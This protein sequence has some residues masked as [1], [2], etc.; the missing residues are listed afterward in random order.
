MVSVGAI[1][2]HLLD[3][4]FPLSAALREAYALARAM[5][6]PA[7]IDWL[8]N[9]MDGYYGEAER[10][11]PPEYRHLMARLFTVDH[12]NHFISLELPS[13]EYRERICHQAVRDSITHLEELLSEANPDHQ[14]V[15]QFP[16][17][18][19]SQLQQLYSAPIQPV[20]KYHRAQLAGILSAVRNRLLD[21]ILDL[22]DRVPGL[23]PE[24]LTEYQRSRIGDAVAEAMK[25][26]APNSAGSS[27]YNFGIMVTAQNVLG[28]V[29]QTG[30]AEADRA[31]TQ[32]LLAELREAIDSLDILEDER[33]LL[34][35]NLD[36]LG[37]EIEREPEPRRAMLDMAWK[38]IQGFVAAEGTLQGIDRV[39]LILNTVGTLLG[40]QPS[41]PGPGVI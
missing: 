12:W 34:T 26:E 5:R 33:E 3:A 19:A 9:E 31:A 21:L 18:A 41:P 8:K 28:P 10:P 25:P 38:A 23:E 7:L 17:S 37:A 39:R 20:L 40:V 4:E 2:D 30:P 22:E 35:K 1:R 24:R 16:P 6:E 36:V 13:D 29:S 15:N 11:E 27:T 14:L 32:A